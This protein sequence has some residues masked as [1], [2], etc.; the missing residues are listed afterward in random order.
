MARIAVTGGSGKAGRSVVHDLLEHDH[1]V[2]NVDRV[3]S[4]ESSTV[5]EDHELRPETSYALSKVLG[6]EMARQFSRW[7]LWGYVDSSHVAQ[8][9]RR[10]LATHGTLL[11]IGKARR[12]LG[13]DPA[14]TWRSL[15]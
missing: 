9:V 2:L 14:F 7:S 6:E 8:S 3:P 11:G 4:A 12:L 1:Q 5:D 10:A 13:Y 15:F